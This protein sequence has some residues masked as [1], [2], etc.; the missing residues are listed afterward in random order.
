MI[1]SF[2]YIL[3]YYTNKNQILKKFLHINYFYRDT[4]WLH[5]N[6]YN[7]KVFFFFFFFFFFSK[8]FKIVFSDKM[9]DKMF[10]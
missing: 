3:L 6:E 8:R 7:L 5:N 2:N 4:G 9:S 1:I 10:K